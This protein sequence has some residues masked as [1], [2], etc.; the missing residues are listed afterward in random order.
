MFTNGLSTSPSNYAPWPRGDVLDN[1][2]QQRRLMN[3]MFGVERVKM[4]YGWSMG[5][6]QAYHWAAA[7]PAEVARAVVLC[8]SARTAV[9]NQVF[10]RTQMA[11]LEAAPEYDGTALFSARAGKRR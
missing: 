3:E 9:H 10:L 11:I 6:Q 7:H 8:G 2:T 4:V 1:V 5:A